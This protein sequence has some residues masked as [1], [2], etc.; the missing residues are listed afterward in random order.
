[1]TDRSHKWNLYTNFSYSIFLITN[2]TDYAND[3]VVVV[4]QTWCGV[5][6]INKLQ[7]PE[8]KSVVQDQ[9][10]GARGL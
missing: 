6:G 2:I 4:M 8:S 5:Y 10:E 7:R 9:S 3:S 1:M